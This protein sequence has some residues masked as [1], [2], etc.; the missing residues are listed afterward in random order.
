MPPDPPKQGSTGNIAQF[1]VNWRDIRLPRWSSADDEFLAIPIPDNSLESEHIM[2]GDLA[3]V[4][5]T[6]AIYPGDIIAIF[7]DHGDVIYRFT[8]TR[9]NGVIRGKVIRV[10]RDL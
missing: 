6:S 2:S 3:I 1:P 7:T 8:G 10:E 4:H 9:P 5:L